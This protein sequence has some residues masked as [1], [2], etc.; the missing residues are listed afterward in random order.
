MR[1]AISLSLVIVI[2]T[3]MFIG[4]NFGLGHRIINAQ[5]VYRISE[6]YA[7]ILITGILGFLINKGFIL[8]E[9]KIV[10]WRGK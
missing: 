7:T 6:M 10:H 9:K 2:V 8:V 5:L 3:E 4:T 1:I